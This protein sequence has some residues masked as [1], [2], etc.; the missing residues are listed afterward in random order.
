MDSFKPSKNELYEILHPRVLLQH[1]PLM[2][3]QISLTL[4]YNPLLPLSVKMNNL[5]FNQGS[6]LTFQL[7]SQVASDNLDVTT[8]SVCLTNQ[9]GSWK[10]KTLAKTEFLIVSVASWL[11]LVSSSVNGTQEHHT[12]TLKKALKLRPLLSEAIALRAHN[13]TLPQ[14]QQE[15]RR[16]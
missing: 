4:F 13:T 7:I 16:R 11:L 1:L 3:C 2:I 6:T 15:N 10:L 9:T 8:I 12:F 5:T 14:V